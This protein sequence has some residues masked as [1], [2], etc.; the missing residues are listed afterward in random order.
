MARARLGRLNEMR[1]RK[2]LL[3][4]VGMMLV[5]ACAIAI[6]PVRT[7]LLRAMG[8]FLVT[9]DQVQRADVIVLSVDSDGAGVL[10]ATDLVHEHVADRVALF[11]DPPDSVDREFLRRGVSYHNA[12]AVSVS[13]LRDLGID[14]VE[15]IPRT[16][17]GTNDESHDLAAWCSERGY[18][19]VIFVSTI[20]HS[21]RTARMLARAT[22]GRALKLSVRASRY[23]AF[24][25]DTWWKSRTGVR[26]E[27]VESEKLLIDLLLHPLS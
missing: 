17:T 26:T 22:R 9:A 25:P 10:E 21:R 5:V 13:Q 12:A 19:S 6:A 7:S 18:R 14:A 20:D 23:S 3:V 11:A 2:S 24:D 16:V 8:R 1:L 4:V 27:V 15:V